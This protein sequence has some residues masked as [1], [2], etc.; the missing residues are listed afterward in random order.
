MLE[1]V[2]S[3]S[4]LLRK[5]A[6]DLFDVSFFL[7]GL[8]CV[9]GLGAC[10][11]FALLRGRKGRRPSWISL[12]ITRV[13]IFSLVLWPLS[14][15]SLFLAFL[16][17]CYLP[18]YADLSEYSG[19]RCDVSTRR[20]SGILGR[21]SVFLSKYFKNRLVKTVDI[22]EQCIVGLH[23]HGIIP[24]GGSVN[25]A[26]EA[27]RFSELFP[28]MNNRILVAASSCFLVPGFRE[29]LL[30]YGALDCS[31]FNFEDWLRKGSSVFVFPGGAREGLYANPDSDWLD[32][33]RRL[34]FI[35]LAIRFNIPVVPSFTFNEVDAFHQL[36]YSSIEKIPLLPFIR[37]LFQSTWGLS[38]PI[39]CHF[40]PIK[41]VTTE[42][43][44]VIGKPIHFNIQCDNPSDDQVAECL[45]IYISA[46]KRLYAEHAPKYN[47]R[48]RHLTVS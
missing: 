35:R 48:G 16:W 2:S 7:F 21:V 15:L 40:F 39:F 43:V 32:L 12:V 8:Y 42:C 33:T 26:S 28:E 5:A 22:K 27:S 34:G 9:V 25:V 37:R 18:Y 46:L 47:S 14:R 29:L 20:G 17:I 38:L 24:F 44:T 19:S 11:L 45:S 31:R 3:L 6:T 36:H 30:S 23:P 4:L 41:N 13:Y 1:V 10:N